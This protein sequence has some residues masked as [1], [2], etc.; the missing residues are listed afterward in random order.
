M[1]LEVDFA[2]ENAK[3]DPIYGVKTAAEWKKMT[4]AKLKVLEDIEAAGAFLEK[5]E[6]AKIVVTIDTHCVEDNGLLVWTD[7]DANGLLGVCT[8]AK[9]GVMLVR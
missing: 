6:T 9:V 2:G 1:L 4:K 5:H 7:A 8:L 3:V